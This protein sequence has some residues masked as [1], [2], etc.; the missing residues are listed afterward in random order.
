MPETT[1]KTQTRDSKIPDC[2]N[3]DVLMSPGGKGSTRTF[4][5]ISHFSKFELKTIN[6]CAIPDSIL[7]VFIKL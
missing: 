6:V 2:E 3:G 7:S 5:V 1:I 4:L